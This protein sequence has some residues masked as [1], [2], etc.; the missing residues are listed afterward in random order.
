M[1]DRDEEQHREGV[2]QRRSPRRPREA[3]IRLAHDHPGQKR[4]EGHRGAEQLRPRHRDAQ[5]QNQNGQREQFANVSRPS[6]EQPGN[7]PPADVQHHRDQQTDLQHRQAPATATI[8]PAPVRLPNRNSNRQQHQHEHR[9]QILDHQPAD[10]DMADRRVQIVMVGQ[11]AEQ[12]DRAGDGNRQAEHESRGETSAE[13]HFDGCP[14][15]GS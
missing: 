8:W 7:Q 4:A 2:A 1:P 15:P 14:P 12:N 5:C 11:H 9:H 3:E 13:R 6:C 10:G